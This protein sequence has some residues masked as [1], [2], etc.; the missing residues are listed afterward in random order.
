MYAQLLF[1]KCACQSASC[2]SLSTLDESV[3]HLV[4]LYSILSEINIQE[5]NQV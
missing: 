3:T 2:L 5:K 4:L 1:K